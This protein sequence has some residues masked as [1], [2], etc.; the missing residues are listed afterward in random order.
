MQRN[1]FRPVDYFHGNQINSD[2]ASVLAAD[3][4]IE[5]PEKHLLTQNEIFWAEGGPVG[6]AL[7]VGLAVG[8]VAALFAYRPH[9]NTY[10][11]RAQLKPHEFAQ[12]GLAGFLGWHVGYSTGSKLF[13]DSQRLHNHWMAYTYVKTLN[14]FDGRQI[15]TKKP[16]Y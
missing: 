6:L 14:R 5:T 1:Q 15:L 3:E 10:L 2:S 8:G 16:T 4:I 11:R 7:Q 9:L 12:I 13:G